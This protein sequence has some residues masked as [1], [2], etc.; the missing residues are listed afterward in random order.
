MITPLDNR[1]HP[2][3]QRLLRSPASVALVRAVE[4]VW[5]V[6]AGHLGRCV[7][8]WQRHNEAAATARALRS[9]DDRMLRDLGI[10]RSELPSLAHDPRDV[11]RARSA[12]HS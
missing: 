5:R 9:L 4:P 2:L 11:T 10:D 1:I 8:D 12:G 6:L 3:A 7:A